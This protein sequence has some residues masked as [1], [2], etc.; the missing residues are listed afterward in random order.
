[1]DGVPLTLTLTPCLQHFSMPASPLLSPLQ[2]AL[3]LQVALVDGVPRSLTLKA[4]LQHFLDFRITTIQ[5]RARHRLGK[6]EA[7]M[8]LV[9]GLLTALA[10]LDAVVQVGVTI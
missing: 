6:A 4:C 8:H 9:E 2:S 5:R 1:V 3:L 7:R 10:Q